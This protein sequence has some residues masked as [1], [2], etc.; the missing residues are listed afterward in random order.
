MNHEATAHLAIM[1]AYHQLGFNKE[2]S[3]EEVYPRFTDIKEQALKNLE[4]VGINNY[5]I[6]DYQIAQSIWYMDEDDF[7]LWIKEN[8]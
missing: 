8:K 2:A 7:Y 5:V 4:W 1:S 6:F 3:I